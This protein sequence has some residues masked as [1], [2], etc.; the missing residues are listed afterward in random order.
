MAAITDDELLRRVRLIRHGLLGGEVEAAYTLVAAIEHALT[1]GID[2]LPF[3]LDGSQPEPGADAGTVGVQTPYSTDER[4]GLDSHRHD[5]YAE[6]MDGPT[7]FSLIV[8]GSVEGPTHA[9][10]YSTAR[11][12]SERSRI[13]AW[14]AGT[15]EVGEAIGGMLARFGPTATL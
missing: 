12:D 5:A 1:C 13:V 10:L 3:L 9:E 8:T 4:L 6:A 11:N 15:P 7:E 14:L 2:T